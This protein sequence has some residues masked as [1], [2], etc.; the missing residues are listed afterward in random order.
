MDILRNVRR[1]ADEQGDRVVYHTDEENMTYAGL[2][3]WSDL[4]AAYLIK[5]A[6]GAE[7]PVVVYGHKHPLMLVCF[8]ASVKA[9]RAYCPVDTS[10][11]EER[12][13]DII[14]VTETTNVFC[15]EEACSV[16]PEDRTLFRKDLLRILASGGERAGTDTWVKPEDVFYIIFTSGS[17]GKPKG[18]EI[19]CRSLYNYAG[20]AVSMLPDRNEGTAFRFLNQAPFSFDL[21]VMD[22]YLCLATGGTLFPM[23]RE[24]Q[25]S[26]SLLFKSLAGADPQV[27]VS[28]PSFADVCLADPGFCSALMPSLQVFLFCGERLTNRT[29]GKLLER[30]PGARVMNTYGPTESTVCMTETQI[31]EK[32]V[33]EE[34]PLPVGRP[35]SGSPIHILQAD[36]SEAPDGMPGEILITGDTLA[37]GYF[38]APDLTEKAFVTIPEDGQQVRAYRTGDEGYLKDGMLYYNGRLDLQIKLHGYRIELGDIEDNFL[39]LPDVEQVCVVTK[40]RE[41]IVQSIHAFAVMQGGIPADERKTARELRDQLKTYL[42][43]YMIPKKIHFLGQIPVTGNGKADRRC[44]K[45]MLS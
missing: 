12:I 30:F 14:G 24:V 10:T 26:Y 27:W 37:E 15:T 13:R 36:G 25:N 5:E 29:A 2:D 28:T 11:P 17:T 31:T 7:T 3:L 41:G 20:W 18:V 9:G 21:S 6:P 32:T 39:H 34:S 33:R 35:R 22:L 1:Y 4:L 16:L 40:E 8:L 45:E 44:L 23:T 38:H 42:P 19:S 43:A